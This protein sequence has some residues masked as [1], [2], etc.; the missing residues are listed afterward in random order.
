VDMGASF[1]AFPNTPRTLAVGS[2]VPRSII[3][4]PGERAMHLQASPY[5]RRWPESPDVPEFSG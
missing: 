3:S 2:G 5:N 1:L 4:R